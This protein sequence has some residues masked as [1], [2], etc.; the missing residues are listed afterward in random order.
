IMAEE[1]HQAMR[2]AGVAAV[3]DAEAV[4]LET[5]G[6][7]SVVQKG[8]AEALTALEGVRHPPEHGPEAAE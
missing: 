7:L 4:V 6:T 5:D 1:I 3:E 8:Q 2:S